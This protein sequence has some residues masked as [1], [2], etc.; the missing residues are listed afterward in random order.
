[1]R[2]KRIAH[3]FASSRTWSRRPRG[4]VS[5]KLHKRMRKLRPAIVLF[6]CLT[7]CTS[8]DLL[9]PTV[10]PPPPPEIAPNKV[11]GQ[12]CTE[13]PATII[14]PLKVWFVIDDSGS[15]MMNDPNQ[16]RYTG[17]EDLA[18]SL[19]NPGKIFFGGEVFS[20]DR[21]MRFSN[22]R[23]S[24][25]VTLF[26]GEVA[27][28]AGP[29]AGQTPYLGALNLALA[30]I[31]ADIMENAS[32]AK[33]TRYVI[34]FLSDGTPTDSMEP[35][36]IAAENEIMALSAKVGG[37]TLNT[38]LLGGDDPAAIP[39]LQQMASV[40][41]GQYKS[42]P[43][44]DA[45]DYSG[46]DF[47][48]IRRTYEQRFFVMTN[49]SMVPNGN[50]QDVDS[51]QDSLVDSLELMMGTDPTKRDTDG[52]GC[53][54]A[55]EIRVGWDPLSKKAGECTCTAAEVAN[56]TDNDGL[57]DCEEKWIGT[58]PSDSDSDIGKDSATDPDLAADGLDFFEVRD[59]TFNN[60]ATDRDLDG[61]LDLEELRAHTAIDVPDR[62]RDKWAYQYVKFQKAANSD[63]CYEF[64]IDNVTLGHTLKTAE[65]DADENVL[66]L[67]LVESSQD[68]PHHDRIYRV[69][70][71]KVPYAD[72]NRVVNVE[73][74]D[75][76]ITMQAP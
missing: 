41:M 20:G 57:N 23:F 6:S 12:F 40:G 36:I 59:P 39:L 8:V 58:L 64:E 67:H 44:G 50:G 70:R 15:M 72:G 29:G 1:L 61:V 43:N 56:D 34:I 52:D 25:D 45:L 7:G 71:L 10:D 16:H 5:A 76:S 63:R 11:Q 51:D 28:T 30:E 14:F 73:P 32:N 33:R 46:F 3:L 38:V 66:E 9:Y 21:T 27:A 53:N 17:V 2:I 65:H 18:T 4:T 69:A 26:N 62:N 31:T 22:P 68:D 42:F 37:I 55:L 24:D 35:E 13:D 60:M 48:T 54:D 74:T 49:T 47:S 19:G 75:F